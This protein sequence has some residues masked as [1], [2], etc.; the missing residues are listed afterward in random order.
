VANISNRLPSEADAAPLD[1]PARWLENPFR[2]DIGARLA[3]A[4]AALSAEPMSWD[5]A[6]GAWRRPTVAGRPSFP[7]LL[8]NRALAADV[9][10]HGLA[11][12]PLALAGRFFLRLGGG[13]TSAAGDWRLDP[14]AD[15]VHRNVSV[16]PGAVVLDLNAGARGRVTLTLTL[17][18]DRPVAVAQLSLSGADAELTCE[19]SWLAGAFEK[20]AEGIWLQAHDPGELDSV[21]AR[22]NSAVPD[23]VR[24]SDLTNAGLYVLPIG[25]VPVAQAS[26]AA[27]G[28]IS[29]ADR[30]FAAELVERTALGRWGAGDHTVLLVVAEDVSTAESIADEW[31]TTPALSSEQLA[32]W[33]KV[34]ERFNLSL[35]DERLARQARFSLHNSL[36][37]RARREDGREIFVHGRRER[38]YGDCAHLHQSYQMHLPALASGEGESVRAE[39]EA[40]LE[41]QHDD[42]DLARAPRPGAGSH[43]YVGLYSNAH[44]LLAV[45][46][47]LAWTGDRD[48]LD[49]QVGGE[50]VLARTCRA[51]DF[52]LANESDG[53][54]APCG[55]LDAWPPDVRA[56]S[57][58]S[59]AG[60]M[61]LEALSRVLS[62]SGEEATGA[63]YG[64]AAAALRLRLLERCYDPG[65]GLFA[66]H[67]FAD[68]VQGGTE[69]DFWAHTQ[70][71]AAL[72]RVA[73]DRRGL[74]A[75]RRNCLGAGIR[76]VPIS[77]FDSGYVAASTDGDASLSIDSTATWLLASW[78]ELTHLYALAEARC[79]RPDLALSAV[80]SQLPEL[81]H[82]RNPAA[83]P[84][85]YAEKY[86]TP[87]DEPWLCTWAGDPTLIDVLL[88]G[89][90]GIRPELDGLR[91]EPCLPPQWAEGCRAA[92]VWRGA[93]WTLILDSDAEALTVDGAEVDGGLIAPGQPGA[94]HI[95]RVPLAT[96]ER[97]GG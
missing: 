22:N 50:Q 56:Q 11:L 68:G 88:S 1:G 86:L 72:A 29:L 69:E 25:A 40:F 41:L 7:A 15:D 5:R 83:A 60:L 66:E 85:Y 81:L 84:F 32:Y 8:Q 48:F 2:A 59:V 37:S 17:A 92:F 33:E 65:T 76:V 4:R 35:P 62:W 12:Y 46:R 44:L 39:L 21:I 42:G 16:R 90:L 93:D 51:A 63:R 43:P 47:Y 24:P 54:L 14:D 26:A 67:V 87:G 6:H 75:T 57:Q 78:P 70:I 38:G 19:L 71:W 27:D 28:D 77:T 30:V 91:I 64:A 61:G 9:T 53:L 36:F 3:S 97:P 89:F 79:G 96:S 13:V 18:P 58:I 95:V 94:R 45:H 55:W 82:R 74:D 20:R 31:L 49:V 80:E 34:A 73:P 52:L 10:D 23:P